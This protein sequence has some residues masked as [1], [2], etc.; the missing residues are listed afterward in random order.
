MGCLKYWVCCKGA[1]FLYCGRH[2][3]R[4][5]DDDDSGLAGV[6]GVKARSVR[7][8]AAEREAPLTKWSRDNAPLPR[9]PSLA[10]DVDERQLIY[11]Q[12]AQ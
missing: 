10:H 5:P 6:A 3:S 2:A 4:A 9:T 7:E 12:I 11:M 8:L 1:Y